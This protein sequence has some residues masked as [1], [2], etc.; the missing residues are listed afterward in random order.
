M[1]ALTVLVPVT[2]GTAASVATIP[3]VVALGKGAVHAPA[4]LL[5]FGGFAGVLL[6]VSF[7]W[8]SKP[9]RAR[10]EGPL[11]PQ[12]RPPLRV[13]GAL[14][15]AIFLCAAVALMAY[16]AGL[17]LPLDKISAVFVLTL[18]L[19]IWVYLAWR[20][21]RLL[22]KLSR[23]A[24]V[25]LV[26]LLSLLVAVWL[27]WQ[28]AL[29]GT[30]TLT[31]DTLHVLELL[32]LGAMAMTIIVGLFG[33]VYAFAAMVVWG[34]RPRCAVR[35]RTL[36]TASVSSGVA[37][38][39]LSV[40]SLA[41]GSGLHHSLRAKSGPLGRALEEPYSP[42]LP[43]DV[44]SLVVPAGE[45]SSVLEPAS[46]AHFVDA[47]MHDAAAYTL[48]VPM[49]ALFLSGV[50]IAWT[51]IPL[52]GIEV[53]KI[54]C[55]TNA[56]IVARHHRWVRS[57][58]DVVRA[59]LLVNAVVVLCAPGLVALAYI[60][61]SDTG[62]LLHWTRPF[63]ENALRWFGTIFALSI[64][65]GF[66][67]LRLDLGNF[68]VGLRP[69]L[70]VLLDVDNYLREQPMGESSRDLMA[71]RADALLKHTAGS[72]AEPDAYSGVV[73]IAHSQG[74][75]LIADVLRALR[76]QSERSLR[77]PVYLLTMGSPLQIYARCFPGEYGW[78]FSNV[79]C[80]YRSPLPGELGVNMWVNLYRSGDYVGRALRSKLPGTG[81]FP[82][83]LAPDE[84][85]RGSPDHETVIDHC[86][87]AG[88]HTHYW[89][90][91]DEATRSVG[92]RLDAMI[93]LAL[94]EPWAEAE[95]E[96]ASR[97]AACDD[98]TRATPSPAPA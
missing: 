56:D 25:T 54:S 41:L 68:V 28:I 52:V 79:G 66:L 59:A 32:A 39:G 33:V 24:V 31:A 34:R 20:Y 89:D 98:I 55:V 65:L 37:A 51:V 80:G 50:M 15:I 42:I 95:V 8:P 57:A 70:D 75:V 40:V 78:V 83:E 44:W 90:R 27:G 91:H 93:G 12:R 63:A 38:T 67:A 1:F 96:G 22:P 97:C 62:W 45:L 14:V 19:M 88:G 61:T 36:W 17:G 23:Y 73:I 53:R 21:A 16:H 92:Q 46:Q 9:E 77:V 84:T 82:S 29:R 5:L 94:D 86:I 47:V 87:G 35:R 81:G 30:A 26:A 85:G 4:Y 49:T 18:S 60:A 11:P 76:R 58:V 2:F 71:R 6:W 7:F 43:Q 48:P 74:T 72:S 13:I 3:V 69:V 64:G 10:G